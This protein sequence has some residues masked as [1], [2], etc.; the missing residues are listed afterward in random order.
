MEKVKNIKWKIDV[1]AFTHWVPRLA[2]TGVM[3]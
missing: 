1:A 3:I 2:L